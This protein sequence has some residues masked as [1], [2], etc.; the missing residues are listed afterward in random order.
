MN[1]TSRV[2]GGKR[3]LP[4]ALAILLAATGAAVGCVAGSQGGRPPDA[5]IESAATDTIETAAQGNPEAGEEIFAQRCAQCHS[6]DAR[7]PDQRVNLGELRPSFDV[8]VDAVERG[9]I[10]MPSFARR[11]SD[12]EIRDVAAYVTESATR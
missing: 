1:G 7:R 8:V 6:L 4:P 10:V 3:F 5:P 11:L 12:E 9:G 2:W